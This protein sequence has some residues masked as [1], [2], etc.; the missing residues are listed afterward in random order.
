MGFEQEI[1]ELI[2]SK[3]EDNYWDFKECPHEDNASLLHDIICMS[4]SFYKGNRYIIIGVAD[5]TK[6]CEIVG[7]LPEQENRKNQENLITFLRTKKFAGNLRPE[8]ELRTLNIEGYEIDVIIIFDRPNKPYYLIENYKLN[9]ERGKDK[10]VRANHIYTRIGDTN[11]PINESTDLYFIEKMWRERFG[12]DITPLERVKILLKSPLEWFKDIGNVNYSYH[13]QFPEFRIE[14]SETDEIQ[15]IY[16]FFYT[17]SKS[18]LGKASF[19]YHSTTLFELEY[20]YVDE[21]RH[22]ISVPSPKRIKINQQNCYY[23]Y[24]LSSIKGIFHYFLTDGNLEYSAREDSC[25][26]LFFSNEE[27]RLQFESYLKENISEFDK[28]I[29]EYIATDAKER[30]KKANFNVSSNPLFINK[31]RQMFDRWK[32]GSP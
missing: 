29:P 7:L 14:F 1:L 13:K 9:I 16:S 3:R 30:M 11:T 28:L 12:L 27:N 18:Y 5:P 32:K 31:V 6:N 19:K 22:I 8:I 17:N 15:E 20:L 23:Y 10:I 21:M 26:F 24:D 25:Q 2:N 4:N